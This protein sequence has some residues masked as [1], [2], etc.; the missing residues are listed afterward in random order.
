MNLYSMTPEFVVRDGNMTNI[1]SESASKSQKT[2]GYL[3]EKDRK[4]YLVS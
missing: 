3:M 1:S 4:S 2:E